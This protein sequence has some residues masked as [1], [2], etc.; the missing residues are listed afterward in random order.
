[1]QQEIEAKF[2]NVDHDEVRAKLLAKHA[3]C[4]HPMRLMRRELFDYS[5]RQF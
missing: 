3:V 1:M 5:D 2:L 4:V